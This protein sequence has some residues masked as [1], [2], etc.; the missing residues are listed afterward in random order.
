VTARLSDEL[1][2]LAGA[3]DGSHRHQD[4]AADVLLESTQVL[5]WATLTAL[6]AD[7]TWEEVR[8]DRA[9]DTHVEGMTTGLVA[10][11][12][13]SEAASWR[14]DDHPTAPVATRLHATLGLVGQAMT[15]AG[16]TPRTAVAKD[17][18]DLRSHSYLA[19]YF[20]ALEPNNSGEIQRP[21]ASAK[22]AP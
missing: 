5:Y 8:P 7:A 11:L 15:I 13:R 12:L 14:D 4:F 1:Y 19:D 6:R 10:K 18:E 17:L 16:Q 21:S 2:E 22:I 9:L 3:L 20:A